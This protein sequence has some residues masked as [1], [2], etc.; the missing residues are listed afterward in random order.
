MTPDF[1]AALPFLLARLIHAFDYLK[2]KLPPI[3][4]NKATHSL[5]VSRVVG[6]TA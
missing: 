6:S 1:K 4:R 2:L 5:W 3:V